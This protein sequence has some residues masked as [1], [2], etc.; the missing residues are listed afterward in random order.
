MH[1]MHTIVIGDPGVCLSV[2]HATSRGFAVQK[3]L[4]D[5]GPIWGKDQRRNPRYTVSDR[6]EEGGFDAT[7]VQLLWPLVRNV[8]EKWC[9]SILNIE[10]AVWILSVTVKRTDRQTD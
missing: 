2:C 8:C 6:Q 3:R 7:F 5:R 1:E 9:I 4:N 10:V